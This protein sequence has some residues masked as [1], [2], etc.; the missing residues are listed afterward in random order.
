MIG[1]VAMM[2]EMSFGMKGEAACVWQAMRSVFEAG[3]STADLS[4]SSG[5]IKLVA[6]D[7]FGDMVMARLEELL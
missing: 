7:V 4:Q 5:N 6:T 2:L 1:S 3:Y